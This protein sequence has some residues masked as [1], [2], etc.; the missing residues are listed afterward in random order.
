MPEIPSN[1][2]QIIIASTDTNR[3]LITFKPENKVGIE[4]ICGGPVKMADYQRSGSVL[5]TVKNSE[6]LNQIKNAIMF[7]IL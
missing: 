1:I 5:V 3:K 2:D 4:R 7:P 6:Q